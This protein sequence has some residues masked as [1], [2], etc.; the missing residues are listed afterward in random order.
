VSIVAGLVDRELGVCVVAGADAGV[1]RGVARFGAAVSGRRVRHGLASLDAETTAISGGQ[2]R[3]VAGQESIDT[4]NED[5]TCAYDGSEYS[6]GRQAR[7][8]RQNCK[9]DK[10]SVRVPEIS[11][12]II[13]TVWALAFPSPSRTMPIAKASSW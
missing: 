8:V 1:G 5:A 6:I 12:F 2:G 11:P 10:L 7:P 13:P 4:P 9:R 3:I